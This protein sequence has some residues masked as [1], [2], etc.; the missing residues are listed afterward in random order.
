MLNIEGG[1]ESAMKIAADCHSGIP[2]VKYNS[3]N[4]KDSPY[5]DCQVS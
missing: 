3:H 5:A 2:A 1:G 4:Q